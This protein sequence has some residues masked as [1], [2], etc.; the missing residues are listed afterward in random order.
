MRKLVVGIL[1]GA[2]L[3]LAAQPFRAAEVVVRHA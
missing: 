2:L 3:L 1:V